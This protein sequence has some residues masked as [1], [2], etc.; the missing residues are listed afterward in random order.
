MKEKEEKNKQTKHKYFSCSSLYHAPE[1]EREREREYIN[2]NALSSGSSSRKRNPPKRR[3][4]VSFVVVV[5]G[6]TN[7]NFSPRSLLKGRA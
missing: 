5:V 1:N 3:F 7:W 4:C 6:I 2:K